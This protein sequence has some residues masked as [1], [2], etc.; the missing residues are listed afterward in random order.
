[1]VVPFEF[2]DGNFCLYLQR[3][4]IRDPALESPTPDADLQHGR[5]PRRRSMLVAALVAAVRGC[6]DATGLIQLSVGARPARASESRLRRI[7]R[8][9]AQFPSC[10]IINSADS[11]L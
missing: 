4:R 10:R 2:V 6:N 5:I 3:Q 9:L 7:A 8:R 1:V 11:I